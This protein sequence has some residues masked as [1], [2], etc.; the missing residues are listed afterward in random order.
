MD[1]SWGLQDLVSAAVDGGRRVPQ[2]PSIRCLAQCLAI[3]VLNSDFSEEWLPPQVPS[4]IS[5]SILTRMPGGNCTRSELAELQHPVSRVNVGC[6]DVLCA[7]VESA[8]LA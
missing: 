1:W 8:T 6:L 7:W 5:L 4:S 3:H 2:P